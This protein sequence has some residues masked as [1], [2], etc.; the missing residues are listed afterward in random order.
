MLYRPEKVHL[1][2]RVR[3]KAIPLVFFGLA[4]LAMVGWVYLL[5][6]ILLQFVVWCFYN[7]LQ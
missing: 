4:L 5:S 6:S 7:F 2:S 1:L 3:E